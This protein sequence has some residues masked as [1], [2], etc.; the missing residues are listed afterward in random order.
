MPELEMGFRFAAIVC[1][2]VCVCLCVCIQKRNFFA[3]I[4]IADP[5]TLTLTHYYLQKRVYHLPGL[6][7]TGLMY[8]VRL[9]QTDMIII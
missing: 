8:C 2:C 7:E 5:P 9:H 1:V 4:C 3:C 6:T